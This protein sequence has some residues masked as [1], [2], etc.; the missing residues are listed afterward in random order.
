[1]VCAQIMLSVTCHPF[2]G[3]IPFFLHVS[4]AEACCTRRDGK[5]RRVM[6]APR[7]REIR[8]AKGLLYAHSATTVSLR[9][10]KSRDTKQ[11]QMAHPSSFC[12]VATVRSTAPHVRKTSTVRA[13]ELRKL[14]LLKQNHKCVREAHC[15]VMHHLLMHSYFGWAVT[16]PFRLDIHLS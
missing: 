4:T 15:E 2:L 1:M 5:L 6:H 16:S 3:C 13:D 12:S 10:G 7:C 11:F 14:D 8:S 9:K